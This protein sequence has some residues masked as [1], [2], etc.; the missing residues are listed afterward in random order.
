MKT[1]TSKF[2]CE[3]NRAEQI[4]AREGD[5]AEQRSWL[6]QAAHGAGYDVPMV[7]R[8]IRETEAA[9]AQLRG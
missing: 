5:L 2:L 3:M 4:A 6:T 1:T 8:W 7:R 9:L